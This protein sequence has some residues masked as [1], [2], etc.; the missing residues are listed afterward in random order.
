MFFFFPDIAAD[1]D[2][3][4]GYEFLNQELQKIT[5]QASSAQGR[6]DKLVR[7]WRL[8]GEERL[9]YIHIEVQSQH[10]TLFA[11]RT[12][13]YYYRIFDNYQKPVVTLVIFGDE[14]S[15]WQPT[16]YKQEL[17]GCKVNFEYP[18]VKLNH[19]EARLEELEQSNNPFA[20]VVQAHLHTKAT[21]HKPEKR[22]ALKWQLTRRLYEK[23][24]SKEYILQLYHF[25]DWLMY[26]P[27]KF[28]KQFN[29]QLNE[30]E[31]ERK[32][33]YV[34]S[35]ERFAMEKFRQQGAQRGELQNARKFVLRG[36]DRRFGSVPP[37][38]SERIKVIDN[39]SQLELLY[40]YL[41]D[42][43]TLSA[44]EQRFDELT[45]SEAVTTA[46]EE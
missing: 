21:K 4:R 11:R 36:L 24:Y 23:G 46:P 16:E 41:L 14:S 44:F 45:K 38:M 2:W 27:P 7:V 9:V 5:R 35:Y 12:F 30:Y 37:V 42:T 22:A 1:I 40:D 15:K 8:S 33:R 18:S 20:V 32:V 10:K 25:I 28:D 6:V 43:D 26:L 13:I 17:W 19:Y 31:E 29:T 3:E 34:T 39:S